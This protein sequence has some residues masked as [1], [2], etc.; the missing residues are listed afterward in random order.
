M[1]L[2]QKIASIYRL[3]LPNLGLNA[4]PRQL[5]RKFVYSHANSE[6]SAVPLKQAL[7]LLSKARVWHRITSTSAN[8]LPLGV[9]TNEKFLKVILLDCGLCSASLG[10]T[11]HQLAS[12]SE[13]TL[14]NNGGMAEQLTG[15]ILRTIFPAYVPPALYHW[16]REKKGA[17][18]EIDYVIQHENQVVAIEVKAGTTGS[19]KSLREFISEKKR[20]LAIRINSDKP[21]I[22]LSQTTDSSGSS[23]EYKLL[24]LPFYLL[25]Q[26]HRLIN[27]SENAHPIE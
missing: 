24:S 14:I 20:N 5:G 27:N 12:I 22:C 21:S 25:G 16:L 4:I 15:Q 3:Q 19:L 18:A 2:A 11:L 23:I 26:I 9:E 13:I 8:G 6:V 17:E 7:E 1:V 10:L